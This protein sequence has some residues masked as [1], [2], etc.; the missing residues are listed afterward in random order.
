M[1]RIFAMF[2]RLH[3]HEEYDGTGIGLAISQKIVQQHRGKIWAK[4]EPGK[5]TTF[6]F[7]IPNQNA[8]N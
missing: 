4:S 7:T 5:G 8:N 6:Y 2:Q 1:E 3:T